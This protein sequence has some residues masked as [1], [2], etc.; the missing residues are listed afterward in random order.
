[1]V[2]VSAKILQGIKVSEKE[3]LM[4]SG[5]FSSWHQESGL[6]SVV[7]SGDPPQELVKVIEMRQ[8]RCLGAQ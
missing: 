8:E 7:N 5:E 2:T 1:M 6:G 3:A 4:V